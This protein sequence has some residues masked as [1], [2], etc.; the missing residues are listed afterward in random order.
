MLATRDEI[1]AR[2]ATAMSA[3][4]REEVPLYGD[5]LDLVADVNAKHEADPS[6]PDVA[7]RVAIERHGAIRLGTAQELSTM[8]RVLA[9]MGMLPVGYY[10]LSQA[11]LPVHATAFR[12]IDAEALEANPFRLFTSLLRVE[13]IDPP[14]LRERATEILSRR[15]I[16]TTRLIDLVERA[17]QQG[18]LS[19]ADATIFVGE[20]LETFRW[21]GEAPVTRDE[22]ARMHEAHRLVAD[23]VCFKGPHIN[24]LTP[25]TLDIDA[26]QREMI[27]RGIPAKAAIEG[28]PARRHPILLRQTSFRALE[29]SVRF[30]GDTVPV[31][32]THT[33]RF[34]E[35]EQR[36]Q[37]LTRRGRALYDR[38]LIEG[39]A[40]GDPARAFDA[41]PDDPREML[42][43]GLGYFHFSLTPEG[44]RHLTSWGEGERWLEW[45][46]A[47][48][49]RADPITY[50]D[51]LPVSAAGIFRSNL[52]DSPAAHGALRAAPNQAA[53]EQ[54][55]GAAVLDEFSLYD[56]QQEH[57][58]ERLRRARE[59]ALRGGR[60]AAKDLE[61]AS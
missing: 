39:R 55:L 38:L 45:V 17:E 14:A 60:S 22:Y 59:E 41:F 35:I 2:F 40:S 6:A 9:V 42:A 37:A 32:G 31:A 10:D 44:A 24:H 15:R 11:G 20:A 8:R 53:F 54:A 36:G 19:D 29:E 28:P 5:L 13:M 23:I 56:A 57:S 46:D 43:Q 61:I 25:R 16:F 33:A 58:L 34:G 18:G 21:H 48:W 51:F 1:R 26:A 4:Y 47:G 52:G 50:E 12:P 30:R 7:A 49:V 3:L 27:H